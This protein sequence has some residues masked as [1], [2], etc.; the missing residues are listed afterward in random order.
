MAFPSLHSIVIKYIL[1][2]IQEPEWN[3]VLTRAKTITKNIDGKK[4]I[5]SSLWIIIIYGLYIFIWI[6]C[7][8]FY[9]LKKNETKTS[10]LKSLKCAQTHILWPSKALYREGR[11]LLFRAP[12]NSDSQW[13]SPTR[14]NSFTCWPESQASH[15]PASLFDQTFKTKNTALEPRDLRGSVTDNA[16]SQQFEVTHKHRPIC[17]VSEKST[18]M[19]TPVR[20]SERAQRHALGL[21]LLF[22]YLFGWNTCVFASGRC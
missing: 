7:Y 14:E 5:T 3:L 15:C 12:R 4:K 16:L 6:I 19:P 17:L 1:A 9:Y 21:S 20:V 2:L 22:I 11:L 8:I 18:V 13:A 10:T